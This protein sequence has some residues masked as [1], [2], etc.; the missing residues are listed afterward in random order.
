MWCPEAND[1]PVQVQRV[2]QM[3]AVYP[4]VLS[5]S[6]VNIPKAAIASHN[7]CS[8]IQ[9]LI[10]LAL[11]D[12]AAST[13]KDADMSDSPCAPQG[14]TNTAA[15][16]HGPT[17]GAGGSSTLQSGAK[18]T[19]AAQARAGGRSTPESGAK[20]L[21]GVGI[22]GSPGGNVHMAAIRAEFERRLE[23]QV[24]SLSLCMQYQLH[25]A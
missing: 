12:S 20:G 23:K 22:A 13:S 9:L 11:T 15:S 4:E 3:K 8:G 10:Q 21:Y 17:A 19:S 25:R 6:Y 5:L 1:L 2:A 18:G 24:R 14:D 16:R 7:H